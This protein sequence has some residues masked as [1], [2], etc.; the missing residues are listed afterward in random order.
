MSFLHTLPIRRTLRLLTLV[1]L[2]SVCTSNVVKEEEVLPVKESKPA[3]APLDMA[4]Q[5][6]ASGITSYENGNYKVAAEQLQKALALNLKVREDEAKAH[7]YQAFMHCV[8][9]RTRQC[10]AAFRN[11]LNADP[12][13][14]LTPAEAGH[15]TWGPVF[16]KLKKSHKPVSKK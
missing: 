3:P 2:C 7:K 4:Q 8:G 5:E 13:F 1:V 9:G 11:A 16:R 15:P 14:D 6:L 10:R 12:T